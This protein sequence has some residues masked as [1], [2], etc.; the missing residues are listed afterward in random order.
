M[1]EAHA[2]TEAALGQPF[3]IALMF[4]TPRLGDLATALAARGIAKAEDTVPSAGNDPDNHAIAIVGMAARL[5]GI[6]SLDDFWTVLAEG[7]S[8]IERFDPAG[9]ED[10]FDPATR[11]RPDY[12]PARAVLADADM[13]D[14]GFFGMRPREAAQMDPQQRVFMEVCHAAL[15]DAGIDPARGGPVGLFAGGSMSTYLIENLLGDRAAQRQFTTGFQLDYAL[16]AGNNSDGISTNAAYRLGL[17]GPVLS[18]NT[19]CSTSLVAIAQAVQALRS[20]AARAM[21]A[22]G[23]SITF[24]QRRG[25]LYQEG[26]M[27]S[28]DGLCR[29]FDAQ[30]GGT[31]FGDGAG[32]VVLKRL[33][34]A[35]ADGDAIRAVIHGVGVNNDGADKMSYTAPSV[36]GQSAAIRMAH[37]DAGVDPAQIGY[38]ECHGTATPLG[39][40]IEVAGLKAAFGPGA[41]CALGSVKGTLGHLDAAAG[42]VSVIKTV[43][44]LERGAIPPMPQFTAL[45]PRIDLSGTDFAVPQAVTDWRDR[46]MA[47]VSSFGV[48]GTN[49]HVVLAAAPP[50]TRDAPPEGLVH[51]PL[52][53]RSPEALAQAAVLLADHLEAGSD[54]LSDVAHTLQAGRAVHD[55]RLAIAASDR[56]DAI[57]QLRAARAPGAPVADRPEVV[58]LFPGQG[59]QYPGMGAGL[60]DSEPDYARWID[61]GAEVLA[62]LIGR[63]IR[64]LIL[65]CDLSPEDA[66]AALRETWIT[67]PALFLTEYA[68]ARLWQARGLEPAACIGH[69]VGEFAAAALS[70]VMSFEGALRLI[71]TRG[72]LMMDQPAGAMLSVRATVDDLRPHLD[73][74]VDLAA[75]N[76]PSLQVVAGPEDAIAALAGRLDAAGIAHQALHASH[77]FHSRMMDPVTAPLHAAAQGV[78]L[79]APDRPIVSAVTGRILSDAEATDPVYWAGQARACVDFHAALAAVTGTRSQVFVEVGPGRTLSAFAAQTLGRGSH[80]GIFQSL[81]DHARSVSDEKMMAVTA[82]NLWAA[83]LDLSWLHG[84]QSG[85]MTVRLPTYPFQRQRHWIAPPEAAPAAA[86]EVSTPRQEVPA[87]SAAVDRRPRLTEELA[88]LLAEMSGEDI[89][90]TE[91]TVSFLELGFDSLFL[92]QVSQAIGRDYGVQIGFR[93]M[94][95]DLSTIDALV[96]HL[97]A[98]MPAE[99]ALAVPDA[100][101]V[102]MPVPAAAP[103]AVAQGPAAMAAGVDGIIQAQ[104]Q[105]MQAVFAQQ[106]QA[107]GGS[108]AAL[109]TTAV[110]APVAQPMPV[111]QPAVATPSDDTTEAL[112]KGFKVGRGPNVTGGTLD[113]AQLAFVRDL[114]A[115][116]A[117]KHAT[118][119]AHTAAHRAVHADPRTAAGFRAEWKELVFPIVA[120]RSKGAYIHDLD[121]NDFVDLVN[122]FGQTAFGHSPDFVVDAVTRQMERGFP[123]GPQADM[124]G[125]VAEKF[126]RAVGH[127][128]VTFC[129]TGSEAVMA[130]MRVARTVTGRDLVV[131]F[132]KD[133][134]GQF[135]E[136]LV[137]GR[138]KAGDPRPLPVAPGIPRSGLANMIVLPYGQ[139]A[140]MEWIRANISEVAAIIV[141]PVQSRH[142]AFRPEAFVRELREVTRDNGT[143]LV[144][145]EVVTGFRTGPRGMQGVWG[146][147]GDMATYGKVVG[148]GMPIGVL[149]G[150]A[151]FMDALDGGAW[152]YGDNSR[153]EAV[154]TFFAGTFVRHP[155]VLAAVDASLDFMAAQGDR[156]WVEAADRTATLAAQMRAA[157]LARGLPDLVEDYSSW[158]VLNLTEADPR[159][160]LLYPLMRMEGIHVMDGFCGFLTT[161][162]GEV[163][164]ARVL[165]AFETALDALLSVGILAQIRTGDA[166]PALTVDTAVPLTD[167]QREIWLSHQMGG[168]ASAAFNECGSL[169]LDGRLDAGALQRAWDDLIA[170]HDALRLRFAQDG[171]TFEVTDPAPQPFAHLDLAGAPDAEAALDALIA[172]EGETPF[173]ITAEPPLRATLVRLADERHVLVMTLHHIVADGWSF[174]VL[175]DD[176]A[177]LYAAS[178]GGRMAELAPAPSFAAHARTAAARVADPATRD[179]W[180]AVL[181][182]APALPDLPLDRP[183]PE[184]KSHAGGSVFHLVPADALKAARKMGGQNGCTLFAVTFAA[185][186]VLV[187]RLSGTRDVVLGVPTAEQQNLPNPDLVGHCVNFLPVRAPMAEGASIAAHLRTVRDQLMAA[188]DHQDTT[189]GAIVEALDVPRT[190][191][192]LPL[193]EIEFNLEKDAPLADMPGLT[194]SF[195]PNAKRAV[196]FDLFFNLAETPE[197]LRIDAHFNA[198]LFDA[199]TVQGW[200]RAYEAVL[201]EM[202]V[203]PDQ[204][205]DGVTLVSEADRLGIGAAMN[206]TARVY[207]RTATLPDLIAH[208]IAAHGDRMAIEDAAGTMSYAALGDRSD[209]IAALLQ[210]RLPGTGQRVALCLP[211]GAEMLAGLIGVLKAGHAY[212]PLDPR[213]PAARLRQIAETAEVAAVLTDDAATAPFA[214]ETGITVIGTRDARAGARPDTVQIAPDHPAYV[215]F[216]SGSTGTPKGVSVPHRAVVNFLTS[217]AAEPGFAADDALLAVTTV[218]FDIAVLE[219]LLPLTQGGRVVIA[220]AEDVVGGFALVDRLKRGDITVMQATPTLWDMVLTAGFAPAEGFCVLCGG[221]PLPADLAARLTADGAALWNLYGPTE[222]TIWSAVK[223]VVPGQPV[224]IGHP[225]ANTEL[226]VL[227]NLG[228]IAPVGATGELNIGGDGLA[229]GYFGRADLTAK[230]FRTISFGGAPRRLYATGDLA[231]RRADG[232]IEVLG[233][234]DTQV[235]LRGFRIELGEIEACLRAVEGVAQAAVGLHTRGNGDRQLVGYVVPKPGADPTPA[236]LSEALGRALPDYMVPRAWVTLSALPQTG[237]GKLDR[238]ALPAPDEAATVTP[239]RQVQAPETDTERRIAAIWARVLGLPEVSVTDTLF[240]LGVD[241]LAVFRI[242]AQMLDAG[243]NLEARH[244]FAHP[245]IRALAAF[246]DG[247]DD[248]GPKRPSLRDFRHGARRAAQGPAE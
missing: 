154:P 107:L 6:A 240:T 22:G 74:T 45:N 81:P 202:V 171:R 49:A 209:A 93:R 67:Q 91:A 10:A 115:R 69:S 169:T 185:M 97:D 212:V 244:M 31:V 20:G 163:E 35:L 84:R 70:G 140:A 129:N 221:E 161:E 189:F 40:P 223:R 143:A 208:A 55:H 201:A 205:A 48:G 42:A 172:A 133:Y 60:Y 24:P 108:P 114:A 110:A 219:L 61:A 106:L 118:S 248:D 19:A 44:M 235:K 96:I 138:A 11:A 146:I 174:G 112:P 213:Q 56:A 188:F 182:D 232:E 191:D 80:R 68:T 89:G 179:H 157:L 54:A 145:D 193:T 206:A 120:D 178:V 77:A 141:E 236:A 85:G 136:V 27:A 215:I 162:H 98:E 166:A 122:G 52:S 83:G 228:R 207:D 192:R 160:T 137:R 200:A 190:L 211:R 194:T 104:L 86:A 3:D 9:A 111:T 238:K 59:A 94:L 197:G 51:L 28:P 50:V 167:S 2:R 149:A 183:R 247:R 66:A 125:P 1:I 153:P 225:I 132:D 113:D 103:V 116:Y 152:S 38:V 216:T 99:A 71:A 82:C 75:R 41:G 246:H 170:R 33:K 210:A 130:A 17:T 128:R 15:E 109:A 30:A 242:A 21:L 76:A 142:P 134:H 231:R 214:A 135:D 147:Q 243:L 199:A 58:F 117:A 173:D 5:P 148:G 73:D 88:A 14:V 102:P 155:L 220:T 226:H 4:D 32:V 150:D 36:A 105:T 62:P 64:P 234:I 119:K 43:L 176:L 16:L 131:V 25:F 203:D 196:N 78:A 198:D 63:D 144:I 168:A 229:L 222:T 237:N 87:M 159:A 7:R 79:N 158:F 227:D 101:P 175:I 195:R 18:I 139:P 39:D 34:D 164:C 72:R 239:L 180:R 90:T 8:V 65:G 165:T 29:P 241:S 123:I 156:L 187:S 26:G 218:M 124:A 100:T 245:S 184:R 217:M 151:S 186:Q 47:G 233:R 37:R 127:E 204:P 46:R 13:F 53:A 126:A 57:A 23:V 230:A 224:T 121:G 177:A 92:G 95:S 181:A 12:V